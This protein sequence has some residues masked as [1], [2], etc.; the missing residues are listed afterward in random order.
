MK[1]AM[2]FGVSLL[3]LATASVSARADCT[4]GR[5]SGGN[6][7][8]NLISGSLICGRPGSGYAGNANDRWQEQHRVG[9]QIFDRKL[10]A[11]PDPETQVGTWTS[12]NGSSATYTATYGTTPYTY[13]VYLITGTT[14]SFCIGTSE[15]VRGTVTAG[16]GVSGNGCAS[17]PP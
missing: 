11:P 10:G 14:Y 16:A 13:A 6:T 4:N 5:I 1:S 17:Y 9:L 15:Q 3:A 8:T 12:T 2:I 7:L